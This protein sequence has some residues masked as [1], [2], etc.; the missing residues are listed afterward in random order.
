[1]ADG[2]GSRGMVLS[3]RG[4]TFVELLIAATM[5]SILL[6]GVGSHLRGGLTVWERARGT[7]E[8][9]QRQRV[10]W[11]R[12]RRD[13]AEAVVY[14]PRSS[15]YGSSDGELPAPHF[16]GDTLAW[17]TLDRTIRPLGSVQ[18]VE[19]RCEKRGEAQGLWRVSQSVD[20]ARAHQEPRVRLVMEGC[21]ALA[22]RFAYLP[23]GG[24]GPLVWESQWQDAYKELPRLIEVTVRLTPAR[25]QPAQEIRRVLMIPIGTLKELPGGGGSPP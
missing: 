12:F 21:E 15:V 2:L 10:G 4:F 3:R 20:Q 24:A 16:A 5:I 13:L 7:I 19:Y 14:D 25:G 8:P 18:T 23:T 11:E 6:A 17:F 1:M 9:L 22:N